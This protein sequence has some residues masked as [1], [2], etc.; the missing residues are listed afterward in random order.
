MSNMKLD[1][2]VRLAT[3]SEDFSSS[4]AMFTDVDEREYLYS[5]NEYT[6]CSSLNPLLWEDLDIDVEDIPDMVDKGDRVVNREIA[7]LI[8]SFDPYGVEFYPVELKGENGVLKNRYLLSVKNIIDAVDYSRSRIIENP[9]PHRPPIVSR[10]AICPE[11]LERIPLNK[12]LV[13]RV[14]ESNTIFFDGRIAEKFL[15][16]LLDGRHF[17]CEATPFDTSELAPVR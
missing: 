9:K 2:N 14:R 1:K 7:E 11:K 5:T 4:D 6:P 12:R 17:L 13:F 8:M 3:L 10:L 15:E 16:G